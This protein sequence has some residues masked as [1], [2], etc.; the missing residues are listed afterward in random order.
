MIDW[1]EMSGNFVLSGQEIEV[2]QQTKYIRGRKTD[3]Q[4]RI[5]VEVEGAVDGITGTV[6]AG[7][8]R[9]LEDRINLT[10]PVEVNSFN[11]PN[12]TI[13]GVNFITSP[14]TLDPDQVISNGISETTQ[15]QFRGYDSGNGDLYVTRINIRGQA[16]YD[17]VKIDGFITNIDE[18]FI[19]VFGIN[20]DT[21]STEFIN[22]EGQIISSVEF[23]NSITVGAKVELINAHLNSITGLISAGTLTI[24][25][26]LEPQS[27][28]NIKYNGNVVYG[29]GTMTGLADNIFN[30]TFE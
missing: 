17:N 28:K 24:D 11:L 4:E 3:I 13:S 22:Q 12:I 29:I 9:F 5:K 14:L 20:V 27:N 2:N 10:L 18:P 16:N 30:S 6:T 7:K 25:T 15:L 1:V 23:F 26:L 19:H 21:T 8:I